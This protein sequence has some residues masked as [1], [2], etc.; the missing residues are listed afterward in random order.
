MDAAP[1]NTFPIPPEALAAQAAMR[2]VLES[3]R[4]IRETVESLLR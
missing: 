1:I 2:E 4:A 3:L